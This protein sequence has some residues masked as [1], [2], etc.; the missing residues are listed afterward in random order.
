MAQGNTGAG[1]SSSQ[2]FQPH[3]AETEILTCCDQTRW[4]T[5]EC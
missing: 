3:S 1:A 2:G 4:E 5:R